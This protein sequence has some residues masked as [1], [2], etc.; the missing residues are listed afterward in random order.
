MSVI[1]A[2]TSIACPPM[3]FLLSDM[4][5]SLGQM[6]VVPDDRWDDMITLLRDD[7]LNPNQEL[8]FIETDQGPFIY[9]PEMH[10]LPNGTNENGIYEFPFT[11][12]GL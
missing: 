6:V 10:Y 1:I 4:A 7:Y 3:P 11:K 12:R 5:D 9:L 8:Q 2:K